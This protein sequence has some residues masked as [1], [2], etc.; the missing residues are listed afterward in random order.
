MDSYI[1]K[2]NTFSF[3]VQSWLLLGKLWLLGFLQ[4]FLKWPVGTYFIGIF[5]L[6]LH[7]LCH[8]YLFV[9]RQMV[10]SVNTVDQIPAS[11]Y[12]SSY[13]IIIEGLRL[14]SLGW[15]NM[16]EYAVIMLCC[17]IHMPDP[18]CIIHHSQEAI[19]LT[20]FVL[21]FQRSHTEICLKIIPVSFIYSFSALKIYM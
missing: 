18:H 7:Q 12:W 10:I 8:W 19:T 1:I 3:S 11:C 5:K 20:A 13:G 21:S 16:L 2:V 14:S 6:C 4:I 9:N 17:A 15:K